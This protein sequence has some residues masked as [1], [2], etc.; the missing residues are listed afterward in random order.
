MNRTARQRL[1]RLARKAGHYIP[2]AGAA[3]DVARFAHERR[4]KK[5]GET[6]DLREWERLNRGV[7][8]YGHLRM[9]KDAG[10]APGTGSFPTHDPGKQP[11][12]PEATR[13]AA[14]R[15]GVKE[16]MAQTRGELDVAMSAPGLTGTWDTRV[17]V[18]ERMERRP[19]DRGGKGVPVW[20]RALHQMTGVKHS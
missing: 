9:R 15:A 2:N 5:K 19:G 7:R 11:K 12:R 17:N 8:P 10:L 20:I 1:S 6:I 18:D 14:W 13:D 16:A 3:V 4:G